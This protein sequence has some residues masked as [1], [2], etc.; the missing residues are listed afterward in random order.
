MGRGGGDGRGDGFPVHRLLRG[1]RR[2]GYS[3]PRCLFGQ[4]TRRAGV[5]PGVSELLGPFAVTLE[6]SITSRVLRRQDSLASSIGQDAYDALSEYELA[7]VQYV[8]AKGRVSV[9]ELAEHLGRSEKVS[10]STLRR[11]AEIG[12]LE[13]HGSNRNDPSQYYDLKR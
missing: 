3:R 5:V 8:Y 10:R 13:W 6:N 4:K 7:A 9:R 1:L 2:H 11:L 12:I